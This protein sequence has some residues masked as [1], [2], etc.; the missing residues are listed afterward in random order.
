MT[1]ATYTV[2]KTSPAG[3]R[4]GL[5]EYAAL[6]AVI[7]HNRL[8]YWRIV[9]P[10]NSNLTF[11]YQEG[12]EVVRN[13][14]T[15][16]SG[17]ITAFERVNKRPD[18]YWRFTGRCGLQHIAD[19]V[20]LPVVD[21]SAWSTQSHDERSGYAENVV[22]A[23][24][25]YN[26]GPNALTARRVSGLTIETSQN[27]G[28]SVSGKARFVSLLELV[29]EL[30]FAGGIGVRVINKEVQVYA[31]SDKSGSVTFSVELGNLQEYN[32][33]GDRPTYNHVYGGG[34]NEGT[35]RLISDDGDATSIASYGRIEKFIDHRQQDTQ[36]DLDDKVAE[37][38]LDVQERASIN[39]VPTTNDLGDMRP[40]DDFYL[41]DTI[42]VTLDGVEL[43]AEVQ[44]LAV[45]DSEYN[46]HER[47][48]VGAFG[49][50]M[51]NTS[52]V[53]PTLLLEKRISN[54][55]RQ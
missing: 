34:A 43:I 47:I 12:I 20:A 8:G 30:A 46:K 1:V 23:Y 45:V 42:T 3:L 10:G 39:A 35:S 25:D 17:P 36:G 31:I 13:G 16:M 41:G 32:Y 54:L 27:R 2:F 7:R 4:T 9:V 6:E 48:Q 18:D 49:I 26:A 29:Q 38:L 33:E 52:I 21:G 24:I 44:E 19:R 15:I 28:S 14:S 40:F 22:K 55:E 51:D 53:A 50:S 5:V 37:D 11:A